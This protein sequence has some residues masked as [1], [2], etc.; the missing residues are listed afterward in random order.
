MDLLL[1]PKEKYTLGFETELTHSN[2]RNVGSSAKFSL[3]NRNALRGAELFKVSFQASW[4]NGNNGPG[5]AV[6]AD[7]S[8]EIRRLIAPFGISKF[9]QI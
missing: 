5:W 7:V 3:T 9:V 1:A 6:G 8:L 2:I 4:F